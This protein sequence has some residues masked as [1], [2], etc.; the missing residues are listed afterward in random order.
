M[1]ATAPTYH[2]DFGGLWT[3]RTDAE[4]EI[5]RRRAAGE[6]T[7]EQAEQ[8]RSW[9]TNGYIVLE[10]A[11]PADAID[12]FREDVTR[13]Y[14]EGDQRVLVRTPANPHGYEPL[15]AGTSPAT[16]RLVDSYAHYPSARELL[17]AQPIVDWLRLVFG[18]DP[19]LFQSLTFDRGSQQGMHQDTAYVVVSS[20]LE[21]AASW[22]ALEDIREGSGELM[23][24]ERSHRLPEYK[25]SG[26]Y[27]H[28]NPERDG[29]EQH[30]EWATLLNVNAEKLGMPRRTF[31]PK[32]GDVLIWSADLVHGGAPP[33]DESLTRR[34]LV[35]HYCPR[36][37]APNWFTYRKDRFAIVPA[38]GGYFAS[39]HYDL[40]GEPDAEYPTARGPQAAPERPAPPDVAAA[41]AAVEAAV[42]A[43]LQQ[44][45]PA[46]PAAS[47]EPEPEPSR[48]PRSEPAPSAE[49]EPPPSAAEQQAVR[50]AQP[51]TP[52]GQRHPVRRRNGG[53]VGKI[54]GMLDR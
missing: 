13:A 42:T 16:A 26:A 31:V 18:D 35:G 21:L 44:D 49:P 5:A 4:Q 33:T 20:P 11:V 25:F 22:I 7:D 36:T 39:E 43:R 28:W 27:K 10:G 14:E 32:K 29:D 34:S 2:S 12:R 41:A 40:S 3:D 52:A 9:A 1:S 15:R 30:G 24:Y 6:I 38:G 50:D 51:A 45:A 53:L 47:A 48:A 46:A 23:Y 8:L 54:R 19:M 17:F 37:V